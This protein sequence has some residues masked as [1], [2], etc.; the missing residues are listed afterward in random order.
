MDRSTIFKWENQLIISTGSFS[1]SQTVTNYQR[2]LHM[3][4]S[5]THD[6]F[7]LMM[8]FSRGTNHPEHGPPGYITNDID[9][10]VGGFILV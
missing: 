6:V 3:E 2:V 1:S 8:G 7:L 9:D 10:I 4:F 5:L